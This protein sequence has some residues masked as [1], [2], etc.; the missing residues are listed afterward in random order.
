M[1][2]AP[3][4]SP[5]HPLGSLGL[6][7]ALTLQVLATPAVLAERVREPL[8]G[9]VYRPGAGPVYRPAAEPLYRPGAAP[10]VRPAPVAR[11]V[12]RPVAAPVYRPAARPVVYTGRPTAWSAR[13]SNGGY[14]G[15]RSWRTGWYAWT[16][17]SWGWWNTNAVAWGVAGLATAATITALI[18]NASRNQTPVIVVPQTSYQLNYG[19]IQAVG[20]AGVNFVYSSNVNGP[21]YS[22]NADCNAGLLNGGTPLTLQD[23]QLLNTACQVAYGAAGA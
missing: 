18:N 17:S 7:S 2:N 13:W 12:V 16:P 19:S 5:H 23:A 15:Y 11:P 22:G 4:S 3:S 9:G 14:W 6:V 10:G 8:G 20:T 1:P 21:Y